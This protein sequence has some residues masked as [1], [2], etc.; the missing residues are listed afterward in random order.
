MTRR[1]IPPRD[2]VESP[3]PSTEWDVAD[4]AWAKEQKP[5]V[6]T[7]DWTAPA[8]LGLESVHAMRN[9]DGSLVG[10]EADT[11]PPIAGEVITSATLPA[12]TEY[13]LER[14]PDRTVRLD[15]V[16]AL[17]SECIDRCTGGGS[18]GLAEM[19]ALREMIEKL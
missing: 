9:A 5:P 2:T 7:G 8:A 6:E 16:L 19:R 10:L 13:K 15:E 3:P 17:V 11:E 18:M 1:R 12:T 4:A 14:R